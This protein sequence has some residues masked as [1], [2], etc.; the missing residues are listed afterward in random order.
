MNNEKQSWFSKLLIEIR[1]YYMLSLFLFLFLCSLSFYKNLILEKDSLSNIQYW[2][3]FV[4]A[5]ILAKILLI[6]MFL[7][8]GERFLER[9]LIIP[10]IYKTIVFCLFII[11]FAF[12]EHFVVGLLS[13]KGLSEL[14]ATITYKYFI[15]I[16]GRIPIFISVSLPLFGLMEV[17]RIMGKNR[18]FTLFFRRSQYD[19]Q[20]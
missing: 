2:Y 4:E 13:G 11:F 19:D 12:L 5:L 18:L 15:G 20:K 3:N 14:S 7:R 9:S 10:T 17:S 6:G 1:T 16:M 8:L